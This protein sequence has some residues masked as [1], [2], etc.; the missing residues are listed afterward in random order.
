[1]SI[2]PVVQAGPELTAAQL[3]RYARHLVI[4]EVGTLGQRRITNARVLCVGAGGLGS[5][6]LM[7]L[8]AAGVGTLGIIDC[9]VVDESNLQRQIIHG[10][11]DIGRK[12]IESA[13]AK[14]QE[15]NPDVSVEIHDMRL[16]RENVLEL[17]SRY[18]IIVDGTDNFGTRYLIND[19]CVILNKPC[20]WGSIYRFDGQ[21]SVFWSEHGPC[22]R[23]LHPTPPPKGMVPNCAEGGVLGSLCATIG[24]IQA[25]ETIKLITGVGNVLVGSVI[26]YDGLEMDMKKISVERDPKCVVCADASAAQLMDDYEEF[27]GVNSFASEITA[28]ELA[29]RISS[30]E[31]FQLIDVRE[32]YEW[33]ESRI[34]G[35]ILI[36]QAEFY[37]GRAQLKIS[38]HRPVV[39]YCH[40]GVRS[41]HA[42]DALKQSGFSQVS[43]LYG[44]IVSWDDYVR[45][46]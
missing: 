28:Q 21:A 11:S 27:C 32:P 25:T 16:D 10:H 29:Q 34:E 30:G 14:I 38:L 46:G 7:Y 33:D 5:P 17:F 45:N 40:L 12:K 23:C 19:A 31:D 36:P 20:V 44:G 22:Y 1:M 3:R 42:L 39:L 43:H 9:D 2:P 37:D 24:S 13:R 4:P 26:I 6:V 15:I 41:A 8:A 35:A 18:D